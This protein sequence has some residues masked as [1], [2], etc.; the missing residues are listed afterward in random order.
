MKLL[1]FGEILWDVYPDNKKIGGA[2]LNFAAHFSKQGGDAYMLSSVGDDELGS[3]ALDSVKSFGIKTDYINISEKETGK[4]LVTL[5]ENQIPSYNLLDGVAWDYIENKNVLSEDFDVLY[6]GTLALRHGENRK[7][8][9]SITEVGH[10]KEIF[11]DVNIRAPYYNKENILFCLTYATILKI[12]DEEL[13]IILDALGMGYSDNLKD[14]ASKI[15]EKYSKIKLIIITLGSKG[16]VA[17][18]VQNRVFETADCVKV[19]VVST[20][21]AGDSFSATFLSEYF[22]GKSVK[23]CLEFASKIAAY[24]VSE[25][26]AVP[27]Y[28]IKDF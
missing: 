10:F 18:D 4:C 2:P 24:V 8:L 28:N 15:S 21:G 25:Y 1:S 7:F 26:A 14:I 12:S 17:Y 3:L 20:V 27:E 23:S 13:P 11:V 5:D 16:S 19:K 6:F 9:K 22:K